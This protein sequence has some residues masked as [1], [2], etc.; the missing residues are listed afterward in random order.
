MAG[1]LQKPARFSQLPPE[2][3]E[4]ILDGEVERLLYTRAFA[5]T[6]SKVEKIERQ[7]QQEF[8]DDQ[9]VSRWINQEALSDLEFAS[10]VLDMYEKYLLKRIDKAEGNFAETS[11]LGL[12]ATKLR[13][14]RL[15]IKKQLDEQRRGNE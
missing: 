11:R 10:A 7:L 15:D 1:L 2:A 3:R 12:L 5:L 8:P 13:K 6:D 4:F 14:Q 9:N